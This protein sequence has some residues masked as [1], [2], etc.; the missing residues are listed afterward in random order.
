MKII[1]S[2]IL[3][4]YMSF[5]HAEGLH[6][7]LA[8]ED[9]ELTLEGVFDADIHARK[10]LPS[11]SQ[12]LQIAADSLTIIY[13]NEAKI[14]TKNGYCIFQV[15]E[16]KTIV[17]FDFY[18]DYKTPLSEVEQ[19]IDVARKALGVGGGFNKEKTS[20]ILKKDFFDPSTALDRLSKPIGCGGNQTEKWNGIL[21]V[22]NSY[23]EE[24]PFRFIWS[25]S[26]RY[27]RP[28]DWPKSRP[29]TE[30]IQVPKGY[31]HLSIEPLPRPNREAEKQQAIEEANSI[32]DYRDPEQAA[33]KIEERKKVKN[34]TLEPKKT[35]Q[36]KE[37]SASSINWLW[38]VVGAVLIILASIG[39]RMWKKSHR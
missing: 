21:R 7:T 31:E 34:L 6:L 22:R 9:K 16:G 39:L 2:Y 33:K 10:L 28:V 35:I 32:I 1:Y 8:L 30:P 37:D 4:A 3:I 17:S 15:R 13:P 25:S 24:R 11:S 14:T 19:R 20:A 36:P 23:D 26:F 38:L 27:E 18:E 12:V 29:R 5:L